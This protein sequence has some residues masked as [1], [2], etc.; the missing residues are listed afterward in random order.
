[1]EMVLL[2]KVG[3]DRPVFS[4]FSADVVGPCGFWGQTGATVVWFGIFYPLWA[5]R[6]SLMNHSVFEL[7]H[8][9]I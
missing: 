9:A 6:M 1:M 4:S 5:N 8:L 7:S 2:Y 3:Y